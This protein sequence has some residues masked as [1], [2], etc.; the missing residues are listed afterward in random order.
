MSRGVLSIFCDVCS[1]QK[2]LFK[3]LVACRRGIGGLP[4][5][6][7]VV[8]NQVGDR[9]E[10]R[11]PMKRVLPVLLIA[12]LLGGCYTEFLTTEVEDT[13]DSLYTPTP[14][15]LPPDPPPPGLCPCPGLPPP[16]LIIQAP[17]RAVAP[18]P[19]PPETR[20]DFGSTRGDVQQDRT[21]RS[22]DGG[23]TEGRGR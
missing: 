22:S 6:T 16:V 17:D 14:S 2:S 7:N 3:I 15:Q 18:A 21:G 20:R 8:L 23:R 19:A 4:R 13:T 12:F 11:I 5:G 9:R 1:A 10:R